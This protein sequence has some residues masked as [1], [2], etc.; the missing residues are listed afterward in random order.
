VRTRDIVRP[1]APDHTK[2]LVVMNL[3][4]MALVAV[5]FKGRLHVPSRSALSSPPFVRIATQVLELK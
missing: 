3:G 4:G 5:N 1:S 2:G